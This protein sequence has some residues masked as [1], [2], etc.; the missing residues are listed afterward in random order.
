MDYKDKLFINLI[1][2]SAEKDLIQQEKTIPSQFLSQ[3]FSFSR[4]EVFLHPF[5]VGF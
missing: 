5:Y 3:L 1:I 4:Q 2:K